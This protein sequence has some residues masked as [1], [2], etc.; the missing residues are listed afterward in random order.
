MCTNDVWIGETESCYTLE[1]SSGVSRGCSLDDLDTCSDNSC[2]AC[3]SSSCNTKTLNYFKCYQ[4]D[5]KVSGQESC[6]EEA[7]GLTA[8]ECPGDEQK[9]SEL[10]CYLLKK[11]DDS[12]ER[13]CLSQLGAS[14]KNDCREDDSEAACQLCLEEGCNNQSGAASLAA[15]STLAL[16]LVAFLVWY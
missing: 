11:D 12:V 6:A 13:G 5:S 14:V 2:E 10:G 3:T 1:T 8:T 15:M 7:D 4:C 9:Y 16:L